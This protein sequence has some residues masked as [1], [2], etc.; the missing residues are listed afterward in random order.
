MKGVFFDDEEKYKHKSEN[1]RKQSNLVRLVLSTGIV[2]D[3][4]HAEYV[5]LYIM[6]FL[7][8]I[9]I[10]IFIF[11]N[12]S[13]QINVPLSKINSAMQVNGIH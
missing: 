3:D 6:V 10:V 11:G 2:N 7:I 1:P 4:K 13:G 9:A 5:L 8:V 12:S